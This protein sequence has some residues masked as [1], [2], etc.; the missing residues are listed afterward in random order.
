MC[1]G[2][3]LCVVAWNRLYAAHTM[4]T[5]CDYENENN[6]VAFKRVGRINKIKQK[7]MRRD[8]TSLSVPFA[9]DNPGLTSSERMSEC[10][11][12]ECDYGWP[13]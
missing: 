12:R 7:A 13:L 10:R 1:P 9:M 8:Q 3:F 5:R 11:H 4:D 2:A 6:Y